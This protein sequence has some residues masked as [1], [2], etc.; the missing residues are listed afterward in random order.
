[1]NI[2]KEV[3]V[4]YRRVETNNGF[5]NEYDGVFVSERDATLHLE[6]TYGKDWNATDK[7]LNDASVLLAV[8]GF[9]VSA[10]NQ[11]VKNTDLDVS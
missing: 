9:P 1:M 5:I 2:A 11:L 8:G 10:E 7:V 6:E 4:A 3:Y